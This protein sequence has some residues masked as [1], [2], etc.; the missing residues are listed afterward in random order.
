MK[1]LSLYQIYI[2]TAAERATNF[3]GDVREGTQY[4]D[5]DT[6]IVSTYAYG[7]WRTPSPGTSDFL[8]LTDTPSSYS[9]ESGKAVAVN[10]GETALEF[11][12]LYDSADFDADFAGKTTTDLAEGANLYSQWLESGAD[13]Y[14]TAGR[15]GVGS[16][17]VGDVSL[18]SEILMATDVDHYAVHAE[19]T[20]KMGAASMQGAHGVYATAVKRTTYASGRMVG[21]RSV[22]RIDGIDGGGSTVA[23]TGV[24]ARA[25][26][27]AGTATQGIAIH[28][29]SAQVSGSGSIATAYGVKVEPQT[30]GTSANYSIHTSSGVVSFGGDL[31]FRQSS[32]IYT[33]TGH[34]TLDPVGE[35]YIPTR[36]GVSVGYA[37]SEALKVSTVM[38]GTYG[39]AP[40]LGVTQARASGGAATDMLTGVLENTVSGNSVYAGRIGFLGSVTTTPTVSYMYLT[41]DPTTA[42]PY[43]N[44]PMT[45]WPDTR[46]GMGKSA[47]SPSGVSSVSII[48]D[49][50]WGSA[51]FGLYVSQNYLTSGATS[52]YGEYVRA[53]NQS[54]GT[55]G[56]LLAGRH[57]ARTEVGSTTTESRALSPIITVN[58]TSQTVY[59][60]ILQ[61]FSG[62]GTVTT[63]YGLYIASMTGAT[64]NFS[65]YT[66]TGRVS[67]GDDIQFRQA[68]TI[69]TTSGLLSLTG[70]DGTVVNGGLG[71]NTAPGTRALNIEYD[72]THTSGTRYGTL[73]IY[74]Y[75]PSVTGTAGVRGSTQRIDVRASSTLSLGYSF[76]AE[77]FVR[78]AATLATYVGVLSSSG[79]ID[80]G[81]I[82][83]VFDFR[84]GGGYTLLNGATINTRYGLF[85][86][87]I[88]VGTGANYAIYTKAGDVRLM[89]SG[90]DKIGFH[91]ASP[92]AKQ[93]VTGSK[94]GNAALAN[95][96]TALANLGL[97]TDSTT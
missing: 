97:I 93:T 69:S 9:G 78:S 25:K 16:P 26:A 50:V 60:I 5:I 20:H 28:A 55:L 81:S 46:I 13:I 2:G 40:A 62:S 1:Y 22:A 31:E 34:L 74:N 83:S 11:V 75:G 68:S 27:E 47:I 71:I 73:S 33:T 63:Q 91:G 43:S 85:V 35:V 23:L 80:G 96:L 79:Y 67:L 10:V 21:V 90:T 76:V 48:S 17:P 14:Y 18:W 49:V 87:D 52:T 86:D 36:A 4:L 53:L 41:A 66:G 19:A 15:V 65:I 7:S 51:S 37:A 77:L 95:L 56:L 59:N 38:F 57:E 88:T 58:G 24:L 30:V 72:Y 32:I 45:I 64:N 39:S 54:G 6:G 44:A 84:A 89:S 29:E 82:T 42:T 3:S 61:P 70:T 94:G 92:V 12:D 8:S